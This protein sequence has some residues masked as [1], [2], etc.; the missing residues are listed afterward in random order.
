MAC[1]A[2]P[3]PGDLPGKTP[4]LQH[5]S[6][7]SF[8]GLR[9]H[10]T[11]LAPP[12]EVGGGGGRSMSTLLCIR[13][14]VLP[15]RWW[16]CIGPPVSPSVGRQGKGT[17]LAFKRRSH[18]SMGPLSKLW[19]TRAGP[20]IQVCLGYRTHKRP[21]PDQ[22]KG[23]TCVSPLMPLP[24]RMHGQTDGQGLSRCRGMGV[25]KHTHGHGHV[26]GEWQGPGPGP[27]QWHK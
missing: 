2:L 11:K 19:S 10:T 27:R 1:R 7:V 16:I 23:G 25:G 18:W 24:M 20:Q 17:H 15:S 5:Y 4:G 12:E 6:P 13:R 26:Y 3:R 8:R 14:R 21:I 9:G 22:R